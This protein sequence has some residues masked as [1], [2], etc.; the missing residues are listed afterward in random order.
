M[1]LIVVE[2]VCCS[3]LITRTVAHPACTCVQASLFEKPV[4]A[5]SAKASHTEFR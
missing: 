4:N 2:M 3:D 1:L 5:A